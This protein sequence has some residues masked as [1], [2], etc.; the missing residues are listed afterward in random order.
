V[1]TLTFLFTDIE[2]ST[3][4]L[5]RVGERTYAQVLAD[6]HRLIRSALSGGDGQEVATQG[7]GFFAVFSS[8]RACLAAVVEMQRGL[9]AHAWPGGQRVRVRMGVHTGEA[10][11]TASGLV[12]LDV[13]RAA[14]VAAVAYGGQI[15][16]SETTAALVHGS[17]P[18]GTALTDLG[19]HW[20]KDL[21]RPEQIFQLRAPGLQARFPPL[22]SPGN[23]SAAAATRT[24]PRD[25]GSFTGREPELARL[26][27]DVAAGGGQVRIHAIDGMAGIGK[28]TLAVHAAHRLA[29][30]FPDGQFFLPLHAHTPG[31]RPVDPA[32]A[33]ASLLTTAGV[34]AQQIPPGLE[35]RASRWRDHIAGQRILLL[36]DDAAGHDQV[37]PLLPGTADSLVLITS[38]R[39]LTA[40]EVAAVIS[41]EAM[42]PDEAAAL[43]A[44]LAGRADLGSAA[45]PAGEIARLCGYLPLAIGMLA[46]Q[47]RHHPARTAGELAA[48][49]TAASDRLAVMRSE[50]LSVAAAFDL[51]YA[52]LTAVQQRLF[53]RLGLAP[54]PDIDPYGAAALDE[55]SPETSRRRLDELY[56]HHLIT[57]PAPGRYLMHDLLREHARAL[58]VADD[59][60]DARAAA[61]RLADYYAHVA[62]AASKHIATWTTAGGRPPPT[63][64]PASA[65]PLATS[66]EAA[67]W[68]EAERPNLHAAV[69]YAAA[70]EMPQ[71]A[72]AIA[73]AMGGFLRARG[74]W[75]QAAEQYQTALNAARQAGDRAG[76]AGLLDELGLLQQLTGAYPAATAT[77]AE[78]IGLFRDVGDLPGQAYARNHLGLV[79]VDI[80]DYPAAA[81]SHRQALA[82]AR[83]A[84]DQLA[85]AVSLIDLG[86][87]HRLTGDYPA[88]AACYQQAL[89][90]TRSVGSKF[91]E[92]DALCQLGGVRRLTGDYAAAA[93]DERQ[94][95]E[96]FRQLGDRLG[97]AW[98]LDE[99]GLV[100]QLTGDYPA[101]AASVA[102]AME[103]F[104]DLG[105]RLGV[106]K[107]LNSLGQL[108]LQIEAPREA[109][110]HHDEAL[111]IARELGAPHEEALALEGIGCS[112]LHQDPAEA[113]TH[114]RHSLAIYQQIGAP[115]TRRVQDVLGD[116]TKD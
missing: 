61:G 18:P 110:A 5:R 42:S 90:L 88:A 46:S 47:L 52:D 92:A 37:Q 93:A 38:R 59:D 9:E 31:Q 51:S 45:G 83:D 48:Y 56:D 114:L 4:L 87:V 99:L 68:L 67:A 75:D 64:P 57:E 43:L 76:Q 39:R 32:D 108:S 116:L 106:A 19:A 8:P 27:A 78:A 24:L 105:N 113:V 98:A 72:I 86:L 20:L 109:R 54:G 55:T 13:H 23:P 60:V 25:V 49:L 82:L 89:P 91:D 101:A 3:V 62:A 112:F 96:L 33:L 50:N 100:Q 74:H 22:R 10:S 34:P 41:V 35:A 97:Q 30:G 16:L 102:E 12:G 104:R 115:D 77:L 73:A 85:E 17:L 111:A 69:G 95:L 53:L 103:L 70:Q 21:G 36:L 29:P 94:A 40:L 107:A 66:G 1:E 79:Q 7:D 26:L 28:T 14:R 80:A 81:G 84:G 6:H 11:Q 71:Q 15:L 58:A 2:G 65:P 44:R 63:S